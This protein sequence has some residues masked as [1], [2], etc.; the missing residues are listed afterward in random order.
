MEQLIVVGMWCARPECD[1]RP[2]IRQVIN[3]LNFEVEMPAFA[4]MMPVPTYANPRMSARSSSSAFS[5]SG[6]TDSA[7]YDRYSGSSN[8]NPSA[9]TAS[10][11]HSH[12]M[13]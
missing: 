11:S 6:T 10:S 7:S 12:L 2:S 5:G 3:V 1:Q 13:K 8:V 4:L 9:A